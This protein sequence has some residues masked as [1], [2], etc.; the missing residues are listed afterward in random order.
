VNEEIL[1]CTVMQKL[2]HAF[3]WMPDA[4]KVSRGG[5]AFESS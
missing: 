1:R 4:L 2:E 3:T 5:T